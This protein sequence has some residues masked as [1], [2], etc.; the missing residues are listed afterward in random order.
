MG[1]V[2]PGGKFCPLFWSEPRPGSASCSVCEGGSLEE[3]PI[4]G[5]S[6]WFVF[7]FAGFGGS[8]WM[9]RSE[10]VL[11]CLGCRQGGFLD[12]PTLLEYSGLEIL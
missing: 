12:P 8:Q 10:G 6:L 7:V 5:G 4:W 3:R 9:G 11:V 2:C 1:G